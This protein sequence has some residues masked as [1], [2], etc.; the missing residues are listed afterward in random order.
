MTS[1]NVPIDGPKLTN[2]ARTRPARRWRVERRLNTTLTQETVAIVLAILASVLACAG[3]IALAGSNVID[4]YIALFDGSFG[5]QNAALETLVQATP[6]IFTGLAATFAFRAKVWNIGGEGQL[7]AGTMGAFFASQL[8]AD[9]LP[10]LILIPAIMIFAAIGGAL[11]AGLAGV[12]QTRFGVNVIIATVMLNFVIINVLSFLLSDWWQDPASFYYQSERMPDVTA[13]PKLVDGSRLHLGFLI[14]VVMAAVVWFVIERTSFGY[15]VRSVGV[16]ENVARY[17]GIGNA[18]VIILTMLISGAIAG[19]AGAS[20]LT[21]IH[22]RLQLD[23]SDNLGF[24]GIIIA[25]VARLRPAAVV[26]TAI[27][28]GALTN[29]ATTMQLTTG[30]PAALIDVLKGSALVFVLVA[31]VAVNYKLRRVAVDG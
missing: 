25:L 14:A 11:W 15:E 5:S 6:L 31:A 23:I 30:V 7:F 16:N 13:L 18:R 1:V 21:G 26:V 17:G 22:L 29:G 2:P 4:S 10:R 19:L 3:L 8:F 9:S 20:E 27:V 24:T 12:L 28:A